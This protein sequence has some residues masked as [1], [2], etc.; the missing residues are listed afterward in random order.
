M[1]PIILLRDEATTSCLEDQQ[2]LTPPDPSAPKKPTKQESSLEDFL[3]YVDSL[4]SP[5]GYN[6]FPNPLGIMSPSAPV[7]TKRMSMWDEMPTSS[8]D[9]IEFA[10]LR[11]SGGSS[12][13]TMFEIARNGRKVASLTLARPAYKLGETVTAVIDFSGAK[14]PCYHVSLRF[15]CQLLSLG[16]GWLMIYFHP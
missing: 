10:I 16:R 1:S 7:M 6:N 2:A 14:I 11:G 15:S 5:Q 8:K 9:A 4:L 3:S 13:G 12:D